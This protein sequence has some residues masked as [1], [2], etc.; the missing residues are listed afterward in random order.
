MDKETRA[1]FNKIIVLI[2][3]AESE[4]VEA[5]KDGR[6]Q[7]FEDYRYMLGVLKGLSLAIGATEEAFRSLLTD[8]E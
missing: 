7:C 2:R 1:A 6:A 4:T 8:E 3:E 5:L